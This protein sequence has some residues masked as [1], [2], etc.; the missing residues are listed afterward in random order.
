MP[1]TIVVKMWYRDISLTSTCIC[2]FKSGSN[3]YFIEKAKT[4]DS[5]FL[6][7]FFNKSKTETYLKQ[8]AH[9]NST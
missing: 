3:T 2:V 7:I 1:S 4:S 8:K 9:K 6:K 5:M